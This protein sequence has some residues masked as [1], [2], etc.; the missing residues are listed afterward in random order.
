MNKNI[1]VNFC[2][3]L[4]QVIKTEYPAVFKEKIGNKGMV[5]WDKQKQNIP[6]R[7]YCAAAVHCLGDKFDQYQISTLNQQKVKYWPFMIERKKAFIELLSWNGYFFLGLQMSRLEEHKSTKYI[8][9]WP[10]LLDLLLC[11]LFRDWPYIFHWDSY[12]YLWE[13]CPSRGQRILQFQLTFYWKCTTTVVSSPVI[14]VLCI[15]HI[16]EE[17][18]SLVSLSP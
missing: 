8:Y 2:I 16:S 3:V 13:N 9:L 17:P 5:K 10:F 14:P 4:L 18:I 7:V 15:Y 11:T 1:N 6:I 12:P